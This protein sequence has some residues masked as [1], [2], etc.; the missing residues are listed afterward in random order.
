MS[1]GTINLNSVNQS[2]LVN[3]LQGSTMSP[4]G[5][6]AVHHSSPPV[7][8]YLPSAVSG[9]DRMTKLRS[10]LATVQQNCRVLGEILTELSSGSGSPDDMEL[11]EV[12][13]AFSPNFYFD[14]ISHVCL[15]CWSVLPLS[16]EL[17]FCLIFCM[18]SM[19]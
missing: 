5:Q 6:F 13:S 1:G 9:P 7:S 3:I 2:V 11:V 17:T 18:P 19:L 16:F 10:E 4:A 15:V 14:K 8:V 12:F